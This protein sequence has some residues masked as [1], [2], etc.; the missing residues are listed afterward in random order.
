MAV[1]I[2]GVRDGIPTYSVVVSCCEKVEI[3]G[4]YFSKE[5]A[6]KEWVKTVKEF[7]DSGDVYEVIKEHYYARLKDGRHIEVLDAKAYGKL[8]K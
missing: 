4:I 8:T 2:D 7:S 6:V 3:K 5:S 1:E